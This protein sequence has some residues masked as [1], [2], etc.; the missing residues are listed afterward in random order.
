MSRSIGLIL[1]AFAVAAP[2]SASATDWYLTVDGTSSNDGSSWN[3][4]RRDLEALVD[5]AVSPGDT[6][7]LGPGHFRVCELDLSDLSLIGS[8]R[9][10]TVLEA[11]NCIGAIAVI[12]GPAS[13]SHMLIE[14]DEKDA[15]SQYGIVIVGTQSNLAPV[16]VDQVDFYRFGEAIRA[17]AADLYVVDSTIKGTALGIAATSHSDVHV[18][19]SLLT[20]TLDFIEQSTGSLTVTDS[21]FLYGLN[22]AHAGSIDMSGG[23]LRL[24]G[25]R[26]DSTEI[27]LQSVEGEITNNVFYDATTPI[28]TSADG[29]IYIVQNTFRHRGFASPQDP[30]RISEA[31]SR[32]PGSGT[33]TV[34]TCSPDFYTGAVSENHFYGNAVVGYDAAYANT[35]TTDCYFFIGGSAFYTPGATVSFPGSHLE[36]APNLWN[37]AFTIDGS[38]QPTGWNSPLLNASPNLYA[39]SALATDFD[40]VPRRWPADIGAVQGH[41]RLVKGVVG[42]PRTP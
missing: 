12:H 6:V 16:T 13:L 10:Q 26:L 34:V 27:D 9:D 31:R 5:H 25:N 20:N 23:T 11:I 17:V 42:G 2:A 22:G 24:D 21:E 39:S 41:H 4:P 35:G 7:Y 1:V 19:R 33:T 40:G 29:Q 18:H 37:V 3:S 32:R 8:G 30:T 38:F 28:K 14:S 15:F 36:T